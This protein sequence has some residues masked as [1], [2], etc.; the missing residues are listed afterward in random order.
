MWILKYEISL[1]K[2]YELLF[3]AELKGYT[4]MDIKNLYNHINVCL[5][6][7]TRLQEDLLSGYQSIKR[8][9]QFAEYFVPDCDHPFYSWNFQIYTSLGNLL[10]VTLTND[11]CVKS[12]ME[13]QAYNFFITHDHEISGCTILSI[14]IHSLDPHL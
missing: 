3:K 14:L 7:V 6:A 12:S 9:S 8:H 10:L 4:S 5:N 1:P 2:F 11:T 13:P